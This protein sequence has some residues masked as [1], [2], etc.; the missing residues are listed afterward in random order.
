MQVDASECQVFDM[1]GRLL[2]VVT[3]AEGVNLVDAIKAK[4]GMTGVYMVKDGNRVK[5]VSVAR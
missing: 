5:M 4:F 2:G 1:Q 3:R